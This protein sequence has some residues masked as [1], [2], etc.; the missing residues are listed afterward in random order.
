[1]NEQELDE[2]LVE[3]LNEG[4]IEVEYDENLKA[5]FR[6]NDKGRQVVG[7]IMESMP[8]K[9]I[10]KKAWRDMNRGKQ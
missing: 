7:E 5:T 3:L 6:I 8:D 1:M 2:T 9:S 4:L 10:L